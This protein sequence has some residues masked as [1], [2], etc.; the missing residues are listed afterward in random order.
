MRAQLTDALVFVSFISAEC[1][2]P[3]FEEYRVHHCRT[4]LKKFTILT[5]AQRPGIP[6]LL[7][8][9]QAL[10]SFPNFKKKLL[11]FIVK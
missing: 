6:F 1:I 2:A 5:K 7:Q 11:E 8:S 4:N 9:L 3:K 10:S